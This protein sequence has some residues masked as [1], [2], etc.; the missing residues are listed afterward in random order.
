MAKSSAERVA[1][2]RARKKVGTPVP[3]LDA[4]GVVD[5]SKISEEV[6]LASDVDEALIENLRSEEAKELADLEE[7][8]RIARLMALAPAHNADGEL[9]ESQEDVQD[10]A[11]H[12][13]RWRYQSWKDGKTT[14]PY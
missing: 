6:V 5:G 7:R 4:V 11:E 13:A 9:M 3:K 2:Y 1:E 10:R 14:S 8:V 12:Y